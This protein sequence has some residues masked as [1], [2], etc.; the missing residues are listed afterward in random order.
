MITDTWYRGRVVLL[1][2]A[3]HCST[4]Y[5]GMGTSAALV[6]AY[7]L[8]GEINRNP[9]D[10]AGALA[11][12]Q[13]TLRP[14]STGS[15]LGDGIVGYRRFNAGGCVGLVPLDGS[16]MMTVSNRGAFWLCDA[17]TGRTADAGALTSR[18]PVGGLAQATDGA[19][20]LTVALETNS[21]AI[22]AID[23]E[24]T[25]EEF[26][27]RTFIKSDSGDLAG[28]R[29]EVLKLADRSV[30]T[31]RLTEEQ[32][33]EA[34]NEASR[35]LYERL[36]EPLHDRAK[37]LGLELSTERAQRSLAGAPPPGYSG[38]ASCPRWQRRDNDE[39]WLE[40]GSA[41]VI[42]PG[43]PRTLRLSQSR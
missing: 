43:R 25:A 3:A 40:A 15:S 24:P 26:I 10:L 38:G 42:G 4:P 35:L 23:I 5:F 6:G 9:S 13:S 19:G 2:D 1:G 32:A 22:L 39:V 18:L 34:I 33:S 8:A 17:V 27:A 11:A 7:V 14:S 28:Y 20:V 31:P 29:T 16:T 21:T 41:S 12:Y 30:P 37:V 36:G